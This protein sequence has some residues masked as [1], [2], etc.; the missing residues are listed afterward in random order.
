MKSKGKKVEIFRTN[1]LLKDFYE[2]Y[3]RKTFKARINIRYRIDKDTPY[4]MDIQEYSNII[5]EINQSIVELMLYEAFEFKMPSNLGKI[6]IK[7]KKVEPYIDENGKFV[8]PLPVDRRATYLL[9]KKDKEAKKEKRLVYHH[10]DHSG[11]YIAKLHYDKFRANYVGKGFY[12]FKPTRTIKNKITEIM[13]DPFS[14][15]N[16]FKI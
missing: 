14:P 3:A 9:W 15:Y 5:N 1:I 10:N 6:S 8:N 4:Y 12:F 7:K 11:G 16:F 2:F 13:Q